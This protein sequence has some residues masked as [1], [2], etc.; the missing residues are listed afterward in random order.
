[1]QQ[2]RL[3]D[4]NNE[5]H[6]VHDAA[7]DAQ[8]QEEFRPEALQNTA[9]SNV[10]TDGM[11][12][13]LDAHNADATRHEAVSA[14]T[15][16]QTTVASDPPPEE[17]LDARNARQRQDTHVSSTVAEEQLARETRCADDSE[18]PPPSCTS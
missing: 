13:Y 18:P 6:A 5:H 16:S 1:M 2:E 8:N 9:G 3:N 11:N 15:N 7:D 14:E 10:P 12:D 4:A 17:R